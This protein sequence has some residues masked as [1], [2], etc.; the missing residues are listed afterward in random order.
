MSINPYATLVPIPNM[1]AAGGPI[2]P[3]WTMAQQEAQCAAAVENLGWYRTLNPSTHYDSA[4]TVLIPCAQF[5]G[6]YTGPNDVCAYPSSDLYINPWN[7][8]TRSIDEMYLYG[9]SNGGANP[10][11]PA[12]VSRVVLGSL[13][14]I[15]RTY[16]NNFNVTDAF[17]LSGAANILA[18]DIFPVIDIRVTKPSRTSL[19][20]SLLLPGVF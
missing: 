19:V 2:P 10:Y 7:M 9:G 1:V 17:S 11:S 16:L 13:N 4:C 12:Y 18:D 20:F 6:S 3:N 15:W 8:A 14:E 5:P